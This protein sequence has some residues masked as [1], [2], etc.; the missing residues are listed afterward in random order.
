MIRTPVSAPVRAVQVLPSSSEY[1]RTLPPLPPAW[2]TQATSRLAFPTMMRARFTP[3]V[4][5]LPTPAAVNVTALLDV[6]AFRSPNATFAMLVAPPPTATMRPVPVV[7]ASSTCPWLTAYVPG[8]LDFVQV[9]SVPAPEYAYTGPPVVSAEL[10]T[11]CRGKPEANA[12][13]P[14]WK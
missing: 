7:T 3:T 10:K 1:Q 8:R 4:T 6:E 2:F 5:R 13:A 12:S 11:T 9:A 14:Q